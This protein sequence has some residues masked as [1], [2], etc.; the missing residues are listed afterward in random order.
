[1]PAGISFLQR[2]QR[3]F[4]GRRTIDVDGKRLPQLERVIGYRF[5]DPTLLVRSLQH[6]SYSSDGRGGEG[7]ATAVEDANGPVAQGVTRPK[8]LDETSNE[9]LEFLGDAVLSLVVNN[10]L[11]ERYPEKREGALTKM[12]SVIVSKAI[13]SHYA[14]RNDLGEFILMSKNAQRSRVSEADSVLADTLEAVFGAVFLDG[15]F[16][17]AEKCIRSI[18]LS[19]LKDIFYNEDNVNYKSL[20]Q[21][22][23]QALHKV[24]P[25]YQVRSTA[26]PE[27]DKAFVVG[28][29]VKGNLLAAGEGKTKKLAEQEAAKEAYKKL[30]NTDGIE[31]QH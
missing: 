21:E 9:R 6:R 14:K 30:L 4:S 5:K 19:D 23:I 8:T 7:N 2:L 10:Y 13:L 22:Y 29:S 27:H 12:K 18:L 20:L 1:M 16:A 26:G 31:E 15:G 25:R 17:A 3:I 28:V 11:Y 24:P